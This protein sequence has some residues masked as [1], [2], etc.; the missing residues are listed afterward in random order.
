[1]QWSQHVL[2]LH[3]HTHIR[4]VGG[5][6]MLCALQVSVL[7]RFGNPKDER[8]CVNSKSVKFEPKK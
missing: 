8:H 4:F 6:Y 5:I 2:Q 7:Q 3:Y 1:M